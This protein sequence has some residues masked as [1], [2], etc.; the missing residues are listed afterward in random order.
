MVAIGRKL[1]VL[2]RKLRPN[3]HKWSYC[4]WQRN[5]FDKETSK[6]SKAIKELVYN[7]QESLYL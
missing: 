2:G 6:K 3:G 7:Y 1:V 4:F 5:G